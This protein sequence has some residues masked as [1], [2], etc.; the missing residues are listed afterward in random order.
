ME[1]ARNFI[2]NIHDLIDAVGRWFNLTD[3]EKEACH[4]QFEY[5]QK[6]CYDNHSYSPY[7]LS[8]CMERAKAILA[9]C[10]SG[11]SEDARPWTDVDT[12]GV[13]IPT[14]RRKRRR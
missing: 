14:R 9:Q 13:K 10:L 8:G 5:D 7:A 2:R 6:Q 12:D 11:Q 4:K 1:G 3:A